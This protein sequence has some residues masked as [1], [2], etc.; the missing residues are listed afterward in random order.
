[1]KK[2]LYL[3]LVALMALAGCSK[4]S[5]EPQIQVPGAEKFT[6]TITLNKTKATIEDSGEGAAS[7]A[8]EENDE[9]GVVV[10][11][12]FVK[13]VLTDK[14][15]NKFTAELPAGTKLEDGAQIAYPY[16]E[17]DFQNGKFALSF[18]TEYEVADAKAFRLRWAGTLAEQADGTFNAMLEHQTGIFRATYA[19]VPEAATA[20]TLTADQPLAG[21]SN[22][23]TV[24]FSQEK[25]ENM[26]FYFPVPA[27]TYNLFT[28]A[29]TDGTDVIPG[30]QKSLTG[31]DMAV[32]AGVIYRTPTIELNAY[33]KVTSTDD[34]EAGDY[35]LVYPAGNGEYR[36]FS[37]QK[38]M[39]NVVE[40]ADAFKDVH[41]LKNLLSHATEG[42]QMV[43]DENYV[44]VQ[45]EENATLLYL[46]AADEENAKLSVELNSGKNDWSAIGADGK[47][48]L[49]ANVDG[50]AYSV[51]MDHIVVDFDNENANIVVAFNAPDLVSTLKAVRGT[52]VPVTFG[53]AIDFFAEEAGLTA[54][55]KD[56][57]VKGFDKAC[58]LAKEMIDAKLGVNMMT[59]TTQTQVLDV[60]AQY[61][62]N[63]SEYAYSICKQNDVKLFGLATPVGFYAA[64]NGFTFNI[65]MP[66]GV[67]FDTLKS[68]FDQAD[69]DMQAFV[70][71]WKKFDGKWSI[72]GYD[73]FLYKAANKVVFN[74]DGQP[75]F[76]QSTFDVLASVDYSKIGKIYDSYR[77]RVNDNL[78]GVC[79]FKKVQ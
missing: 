2:G 34:L 50:K 77:V 13:F 36:L 40:A 54:E 67:W 55:Q 75:R 52:E 65:P 62:D 30:T 42:Y 57:L 7:F 23:V 70:D 1:M 26:N 12:E 20:V 39:E 31:K 17:E 22:T 35:V 60:F 21:E 64:D 29:L 76:D 53:Y 46:S 32:E 9:I 79:L 15:N 28:V 74:N 4:E 48:T 14:E 41:G 8:W 49:S 18:P 25:T 10:G 71:F 19:S 24:K 16:V 43:L 6:V 11:D 5:V 73:N 68:A 45:G 72:L 27:G 3:S 61:Y 38:T 69:G 37:F 63:Y 56:K 66:G 58:A 33:E 44:T 47:T 51:K 78:E 59:I